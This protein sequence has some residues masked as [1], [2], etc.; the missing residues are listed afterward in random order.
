[1]VN[2]D[3]VEIKLSIARIEEHAEFTRKALEGNGKKGLV[4]KV[5]ENCTALNKGRGAI[6]ALGIITTCLGIIAFIM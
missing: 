6:L 1:M 5:E 3:I 2:K 4:Q